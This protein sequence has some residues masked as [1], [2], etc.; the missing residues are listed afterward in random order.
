M[1]KLVTFPFAYLLFVY[2]AM[3]QILYHLNHNMLQRLVERES[4]HV[5]IDVINDFCF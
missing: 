5:R 3:L 4:V 2:Q 1:I